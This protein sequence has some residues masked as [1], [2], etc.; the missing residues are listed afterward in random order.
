MILH[1]VNPDDTFSGDETTMNQ[2]EQNGT[3]KKSSNITGSTTAGRSSELE[4]ARKLS[5]DQ[6]TISAMEEPD[7]SNIEF[8]IVISCN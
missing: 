3:G 5:G 8:I 4:S 6:T 2:N 1:E 7:G